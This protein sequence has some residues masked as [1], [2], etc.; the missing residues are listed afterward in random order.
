PSRRPRR[1]RQS[2]REYRHGAH[3]SAN[4][5]EGFARRAIMTY[6]GDA[7]EAVSIGDG[8][9]GRRPGSC[10]DRNAFHP[11]KGKLSARGGRKETALAGITQPEGCFSEGVA[12]ANTPSIPRL[13]ATGRRHEVVPIQG[14]EQSR[15]VGWR[16]SSTLR[17]MGWARSG[18][19]SV[20]E[21]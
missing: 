9:R 15:Y 11:R 4:A 10:L 14:R 16:P 21:R 13:T 12:T 1:A 8:F 5:E 17:M 19:V 3:S 7:N 18:T 2:Y 6:S 20:P